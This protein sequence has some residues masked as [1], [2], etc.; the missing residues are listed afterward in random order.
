MTS[1]RSCGEPLFDKNQRLCL[2]HS[3]K[4]HWQKVQKFRQELDEKIKRELSDKATDAVDLT[5]Y[6][7]PESDLS[8]KQFNKTLILRKAQFQGNTCFKGCKFLGPITD[9][10]EAVFE[11]DVSDFSGDTH[12]A[13]ER[14]EFS[15][16]RFASNKNLFSGAIFQAELISFIEAQFQG[17][18]TD[19]SSIQVSGY[20]AYFN[21]AKFRSTTNDFTEAHFGSRFTQFEETEFSGDSTQF[22]EAEF[23]SKMTGFRYAK[24]LS[25]STT[26]DSAIFEGFFTFFQSARFEGDVSFGQAK[27]KSHSITDFTSVRFAGTETSFLDTVF[28]SNHVVFADTRFESN[29]TDFGGARLRGRVTDFNDSRFRGTVRFEGHPATSIFGNV[30]WM[31]NLHIDQPARFYFRHTNLSQVEFRGTDLRDIQFLDVKWH[32]S[33]RR[34][35]LPLLTQR[36]NCLFD[37]AVIRNKFVWPEDERDRELQEEALSILYESVGIPRQDNTAAGTNRSGISSHEKDTWKVDQRH[38]PGDLELVRVAY[39]QLKQNYEANKNYAEAGDFYYGEMEMNRLKLPFLKRYFF[40][41]EALYWITSGYGQ[42]WQNSLV[43]AALIF[44]G[45]PILFLYTGLDVLAQHNP[46]NADYWNA[47]QFNFL[48]VTFQRDIHLLYGPSSLTRNIAI[49]E[50][51]LIPVMLTL[52]ILALRRKFKR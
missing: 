30:A 36:R 9:F 47:L 6:I 16:A 33:P 3:K 27:F 26:F 21:Q 24:F 7:F 31:C 43:L 45:L 51:L 2:F 29:E 20:K 46:L 14:I 10:S 17:A 49:L 42:R 23:N 41:W 50:S 5:G 19:F 34:I 13:G 40:S 44:F 4:D 11:G 35:Y 25:S 1:R 18:R 22:G 48:Q 39:R 52:S 37:E 15:K 12:F 38:P 32:E 28:E 8:G